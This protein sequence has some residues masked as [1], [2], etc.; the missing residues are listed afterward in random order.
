MSSNATVSA[1]R[2]RRPRAGAPVTVAWLGRFLLLLVVAL[3]MGTSARAAEDDDPVVWRDA[4]ADG[5]PRTHLYFFWTRTCP[6]CLEA[7][8]IVQRLDERYPWLVVHS[9]DLGAGPG[10]GAL[11]VRIAESLGDSAQY[12]PALAYCRTLQQGAVEEDT[13]QRSLLDCHAQSRRTQ[14]PDTGST[15]ELPWGGQIDAARLSL[16]VTTIVLAAL[17]AFNPCAFFVLLFLLSLLVHA[18]DRTRMVVVSGVFIAISGLWYFAFM[19]AWLNVFLWFGELR[20][21]TIAAGVIA[22]VMASLNL[23]D[24]WFGN[25]GP[26]LSLSDKAKSSLFARMRRLVRAASWPSALAA[27]I[28][29]AAAANTY[30]LLC[31]AGLP[32]IYTRVLTLADLSSTAYYLYLALYNLV[33]VVP[34]A[35]IAGLFIFTLGSRKLQEHEGRALKLLSGLMMLGLGAALLLAPASLSRLGTSLG[36]LG[37]AVALTAIVFSIERR[38][39]RRDRTSGDDAATS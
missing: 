3:G 16:P 5:T 32:M 10:G 17:D 37:S 15:V 28:V 1:V 19:A 29:L 13:L 9:Y 24:Y 4:D 6:H 27:A 8:P 20:G 14:T 18:R 12:V 25:R 34:L 33:Y 11:Y 22:V 2:S 38:R 30:E 35:A 36:L 23:K 21:V 31:T 7:R 39:T 26:S